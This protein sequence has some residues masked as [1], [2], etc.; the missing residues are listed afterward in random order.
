MR[1]AKIHE[2]FLKA[3]IHY[4]YYARGF[5]ALTP[6]ESDSVVDFM[7]NPTFAVDKYW[8][9]YYHPKALEGPLRFEMWHILRHELEHLL[10]AHP[11]RHKNRQGVMWNIACDME[12]ND[13]IPF[14]APILVLRADSEAFKHLNMSLGDTAENYYNILMSQV[15]PV[16]VNWP[17]LGGT[18][19]GSGVGNKPAEWEIGD[20]ATSKTT[21]VTEAEEVKLREAIANDILYQQK[22]D[23]GTEIPEGIVLWA[24]TIA[25]GKLPKISWKSVV[26]GRIRRIT[27]GR[28]DYSYAKLSRRQEPGDRVIL[29]G[30]IQYMP[31][32]AVIVDTSGSMHDMGEWVAGCLRSVTMMSCTTTVIS[33]DMK[34]RG[35]KA[36]RTWKDARALVGGGGTD[37]EVAAEVICPKYDLVLCLSDGETPW[38]TPW[39]RNL[40]AVIKGRNNVTIKTK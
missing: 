36:L 35:I 18:N 34:Q 16:P 24:E 11:E 19:E 32:M 23:R 12:I 9:F 10:R 26:F 27:A 28:A 20:V 38:P 37:M 40:V 33:W 29:P 2:A 6:I 14:A 13:D 7:G 31:S 15:K 1:M 8:R 5:A 17:S 3:S 21:G 39:P 25:K 4:P 30:T 22:A